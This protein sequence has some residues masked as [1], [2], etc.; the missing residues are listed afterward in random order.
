LVKQCT[1]QYFD[2]TSIHRHQTGPWYCHASHG[3]RCMVQPPRLAV[4][5]ITVKRDVVHKTRST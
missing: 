5:P 2:I 1:V 3:S 4:A